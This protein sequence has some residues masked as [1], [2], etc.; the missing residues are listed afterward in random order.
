M[1]NKATTVTN[2]IPYAIRCRE[3]KDW[4]QMD[5]FGDYTYNHVTVWSYINQ[6]QAGMIAYMS[7]VCVAVLWRN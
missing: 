4:R 7:M 5:I 3:W 1:K 2:M 6:P